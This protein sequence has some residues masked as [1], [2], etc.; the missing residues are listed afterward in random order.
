MF[1]TN[2]NTSLT[3]FLKKVWVKVKYIRNKWLKVQKFYTTLSY[4]VL[5]N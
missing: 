1:Q 2:F 3:K 4:K 5:L